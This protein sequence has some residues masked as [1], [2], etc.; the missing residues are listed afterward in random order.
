MGNK[1]RARRK[2]NSERQKKSSGNK[3]KAKRQ[4]VVDSI[5]PKKTRNW[6]KFLKRVALIPGAIAT[7]LA[8]YGAL[9]KLGISSSETLD[10]NNIFASPF[11]VKN[12]SLFP[13]REVEYMF[14]IVEAQTRKP[15]IEIKN[16]V[17]SQHQKIAT[18]TLRRG[19]SGQTLVR[20]VGG[21]GARVTT[22]DIVVFIRFRPAFLPFRQIEKYRF[23]TKKHVDGSLRWL[24]AP[25]SELSEPVDSPFKEYDKMQRQLGKHRPGQ[26]KP[27]RA[28]S[29][30]Q[31][32][33]ASPPSTS[34]VTP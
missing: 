27:K 10:P 1:G 26:I 2:L 18:P 9:P 12:E 34:G 13:V 33:S 4:H 6:A 7:F 23:T 17:V 14:H 32:G 19:E 21:S 20:L 28:T 30:P 16:N 29:A 3:T 24:P 8:I 5:H 11:I 25:I 22:A 15:S 31:A